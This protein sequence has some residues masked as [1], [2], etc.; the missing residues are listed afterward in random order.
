LTEPKYEKIIQQKEENYKEYL[1]KT[2]LNNKI[3]DILIRYSKTNKTV[4]AT[5][6][7]ENRA[8]MMLN[9]CRLADKFSNF[10][11]GRYSDNDEKINKFQNT[12][13]FLNISS[14]L[15]IVFE[16]DKLDIEDAVNAGISRVN[17]INN[18]IGDEEK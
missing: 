18:R 11:F 12:I 8:R 14:K 3:V 4:L 13:Q 6:C 16:N 1:P 7:R 15:V 5:N 2:K 9:Y 10:Y 17:I